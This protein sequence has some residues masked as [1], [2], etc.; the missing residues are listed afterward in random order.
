MVSKIITRFSVVILV[1]T[2]TLQDGWVFANDQ[3]KDT[4]MASKEYSETKIVITPEKNILNENNT[5][6]IKIQGINDLNQFAIRPYTNNGLAQ[7]GHKNDAWI[8]QANKWSQMPRV[9]SNMQL[10][11]L[12]AYKDIYEVGFEL[13]NLK[14]GK[15]Y[16][17]DVV[18]I[19]SNQYA[20]SQINLINRSLPIKKLENTAKIAS[21]KSLDIDFNTTKKEKK[22]DQQN[23]INNYLA[24]YILLFSISFVAGFK[25]VKFNNASS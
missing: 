11:L 14:S 10:K 5:V 24:F 3:I 6:D 4:T 16:K 23:K 9:K 12:G 1:V 20:Q 13:Q 22:K 19:W 15:I 8:S 18:K 21:T 2:T 7:I 17:T 25:M